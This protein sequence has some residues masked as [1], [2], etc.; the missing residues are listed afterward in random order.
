M[1]INLIARDTGRKEKVI[2]RSVKGASDGGYW[3][4]IRGRWVVVSRFGNCD[5]FTS[6]EIKNIR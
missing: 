1:K 3:V 5:V 2:Y 4:K 6:R